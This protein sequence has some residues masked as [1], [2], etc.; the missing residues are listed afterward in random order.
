MSTMIL[1]R[2]KLAA[3]ILNEI[4]NADFIEGL[5]ADVQKLGKE[6]GDADNPEVKQVLRLY[7]WFEKA[8]EE[9]LVLKAEVNE[10]LKD[11]SEE[12]DTAP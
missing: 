8:R 3:A 7:D 9:Y 1:I 4:G 5:S 10:I 6:A 2:G 11:Q 12:T